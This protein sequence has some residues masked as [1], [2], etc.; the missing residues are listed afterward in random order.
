LDDDGEPLLAIAPEPAPLEAPL[1]APDAPPSPAPS[2]D[3]GGDDPFDDEHPT[4]TS[5][6]RSDQV[7]SARAMAVSHAKAAKVLAFP[8]HH[9]HRKA[10]ESLE[11]SRRQCISGASRRPY[12]R[13]RWVGSLIQPHEMRSSATAFLLCAGFALSCS[14]SSPTSTAGTSASSG[15]WSGSSG[16]GGSG[17]TSG[18]SG[19]GSPA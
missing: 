10:F 12:R 3:G 9:Q 8:P 6:E 15:D 16:G 5:M 1:P 18:G 2:G 7:C 11:S 4:T 17:S 14:S 13:G 19:S